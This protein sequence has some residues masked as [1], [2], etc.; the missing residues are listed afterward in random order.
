MYNW[1]PSLLYL[2]T[3][4]KEKEKRNERGSGKNPITGNV[5][6]SNGEVKSFEITGS[7]FLAMEK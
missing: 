1:I 3:D 7:L 2:Q 4:S 5:F 6:F